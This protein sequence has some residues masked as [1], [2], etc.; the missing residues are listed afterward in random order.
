MQYNG[1]A[2]VDE[3]VDILLREFRETMMHMGYV[4]RRNVRHYC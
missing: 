1:E 3:A 2:G 4:T